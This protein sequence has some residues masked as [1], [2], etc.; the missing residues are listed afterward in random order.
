LNRRRPVLGS[1]ALLAASLV[2]CGR[3]PAVGP[4][5]VARIDRDA[6]PVADFEAFLRDNGAAPDQTR[7]GVVLS[8]LFDQ[9]LD[10]R[11]LRRYAVERALV[12]PEASTRAVVEALLRAN[13]QIEPSPADLEAY[14]E[15]HRELFRRPERVH[16]RQIVAPTREE[17]ERALAEI[18]GGEAFGS[19]ARR[20]AHGPLAA[21]GGDQ[22]LLGRDDLPPAFAEAI[23][24]LPSGGHSGV[25]EAEYGWLIFAVDE[26]LPAAEPTLAEAMEE[27]RAAARREASDRLLASLVSE[28]RSR[29]TTEVYARNLPFRYRGTYAPS[30]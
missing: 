30:T 8:R 1:I 25:L 14:F 15:A 5:V 10:E 18:E 17:A 20:H 26:R 23:F 19:V 24:A 27:V 29:Y 2:A 6:V 7:D 28:A 3:A 22:G 13:P 21:R 16:L 11:L 4:D 9:F 12:R